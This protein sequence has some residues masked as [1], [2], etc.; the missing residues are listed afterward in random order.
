MEKLDF[1]LR[2]VHTLLGVIPL[3]IFLVEHMVV[4]NFITRSPGAFGEAA[5]FME[6]LPFLHV[7]EWLVIFIPLLF[8]A[9]YGLRITTQSKLNPIQYPAFKNWLFSLQ[10][11]TAIIAFIFIALH[12][13]QMKI[14]F[15]GMTISS[16]LVAEIF[17]DPIMIFIYI[18][19]AISVVFHCLNGIVTALIKFGVLVSPRSQKTATLFSGA[20]F[21][22]LSYVVISVVL[23]FANVG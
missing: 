5:R 17:D 7:L 3:S 1:R 9:L 20:V 21:L 22:S 10:R 16:E 18:V 14:S 4:N 13:F 8:H 2:R 12:I 11:V 19:G 15:D 6:S 23:A